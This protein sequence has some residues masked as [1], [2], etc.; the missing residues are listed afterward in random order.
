MLW[1]CGCV[2]LRWCG[3]G[4]VWWCGGV[5]ASHGGPQGCAR[6]VPAAA[7]RAGAGHG[8]AVAGGTRAGRGLPAPFQ[9]RPGL[10]ERKDG[11]QP[12]EVS[13]CWR[14]GAADI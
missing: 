7:T 3:D 13:D 10:L 9:A 6:G 4:M 2:V 11:H 8:S 12:V 14:L 1:L 5:I